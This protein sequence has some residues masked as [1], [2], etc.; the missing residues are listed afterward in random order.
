MTKVSNRVTRS[1]HTSRIGAA[2]A[3]DAFC[4]AVAHFKDAVHPTALTIFTPFERRVSLASLRL[5]EAIGGL[6]AR[7]EPRAISEGL[8]PHQAEL[9]KQYRAGKG[10]HFILTSARGSG[11]SLCFWTWVFDHLLKDP[12]AT[13]ILCFPTQALMWGQTRQCPLVP[14]LNATERS[15]RL[16]AL[17]YFQ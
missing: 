15:D 14:Y 6:V 8:F 16:A 7:Y 1:K 17:W 10:P 13:A 11:K 4:N 9:L 12:K 3:A 2:S 5:P